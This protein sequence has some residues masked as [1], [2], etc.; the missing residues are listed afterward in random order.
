MTP[1]VRL[2]PNYFIR[3][4][5]LGLN[6]EPRLP[7]WGVAHE[8]HELF[9]PTVQPCERGP[10]SLAGLRSIENAL[11][12]GTGSLVII[13]TVSRS[14][15]LQIRLAS[16]RDVVARPTK[17]CLAHI[18]HRRPGTRHQR[19]SRWAECDGQGKAKHE[20]QDPMPDK[21][22]QDR[23]HGKRDE[24][25]QSVFGIHRGSG[26][27]RNRARPPG[28]QPWRS[29]DG[30]GQRRPTQVRSGGG[31]PSAWRSQAA[32]CSGRAMSTHDA[33]LG[34]RPGL[35]YLEHK[36]NIRPVEPSREPL[37]RASAGPADR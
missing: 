31:G 25:G 11:F 35:S 2:S 8:P 22:P 15:S 21:G 3:R 10:V 33:A 4:F 7:G 12:T 9:N 23:E 27:P 36:Q 24:D 19:T 1:S 34:S 18:R 16:I 14:T 32:H 29:S 30:S 5:G 20:G 26:T 37:A 17:D 13:P 6:L 28:R